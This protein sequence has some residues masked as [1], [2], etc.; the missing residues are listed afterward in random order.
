MM[1]PISVFLALLVV[2]T[3][4]LAVTIPVSPGPGTPLQD[5][6]D[7]ASPGATLLLQAGTF[8]EAI[9][10]NKPLTLTSVRTGIVNIDAGSTSASL[11]VDIQSDGVQIKGQSPHRAAGEVLGPLYILGGNNQTEL[12]RIGPNARIVLYNL[13]VG[14]GHSQI[15]RAHV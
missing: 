5:A 13:V 12:I 10:I 9:V 6:I 2:P 11:G 4:A 7:A 14:D 3:S 1:R 8:H 15:G